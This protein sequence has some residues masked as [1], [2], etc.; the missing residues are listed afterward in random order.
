MAFFEQVYTLVAQIPPGFVVSYGQI[1]R[2]CGRPRA[3]RQVGWAMRRCPDG[4]PWHR[5]VLKDGILPGADFAQYQRVLLENEGVPFLPD[6]R[7]DMT[8]CNLLLW[9]G[10]PAE[11]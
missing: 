10:T 4:L 3:A 5:V 9:T 6:G 1:A 8:A 11:K 2:M 7:V